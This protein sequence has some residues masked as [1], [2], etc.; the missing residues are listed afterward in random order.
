M[1]EVKRDFCGQKCPIPVASLTALGLQ[2]EVHK[3]DNLTVL[4]DCPNF[5]ETIR[6]WVERVDKKLLY[7]RTT[8]NGI[9][10]AKIV[11]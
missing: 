9:I 3:G 7:I 1:S 4:S 11:W 8:E 5:E 2:G 10:E 6:K